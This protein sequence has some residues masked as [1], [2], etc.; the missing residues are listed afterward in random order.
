M[1]SDEAATGQAAFKALAN[2]TY[3]L[4]LMDLNL[5]DVVGTEICK[6]IRAN[7]RFAACRYP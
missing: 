6:R 3:D 2:Q 5:P 1:L 7:P 4:I